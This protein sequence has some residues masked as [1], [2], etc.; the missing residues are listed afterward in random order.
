MQKEEET[1]HI[2]EPILWYEMMYCTCREIKL[3]WIILKVE[4]KKKQTHDIINLNLNDDGGREKNPSF[5]FILKYR[6]SK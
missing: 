6:R 3:Q 5:Y 4:K 2:Y 1:Y